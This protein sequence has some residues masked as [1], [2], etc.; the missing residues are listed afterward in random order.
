MPGLGPSLVVAAGLAFGVGYGAGAYGPSRTKKDIGV[1]PPP[2][3]EK[4]DVVKKI[5]TAGGSAMLQGGF[6]GMSR[7][8]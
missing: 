4:Y 6:P 3:V 5:P 1:I 7:A 2:P 8:S